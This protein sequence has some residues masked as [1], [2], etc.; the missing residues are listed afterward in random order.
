MFPEQRKAIIHAYLGRDGLVTQGLRDL[1]LVP[2]PWRG[3]VGRKLIEL[4]DL[5]EVVVGEPESEKK[6]HG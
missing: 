3:Q 2:S 1:R 4:K 6:T 5:I